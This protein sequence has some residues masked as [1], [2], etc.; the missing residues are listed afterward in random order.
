M[1]ELFLVTSDSKIYTEDLHNPPSFDVAA[2]L[3][4]SKLVGRLTCQNI[5]DRTG[6]V[7]TPYKFK[8]FIP[9]PALPSET[10]ALSF[11]DLC[12]DRAHELIKYSSD[13]GKPLLVMWSGGIDSTTLLTALIKTK[14]LDN[15]IVGMSVH[16]IR[17]NP[18]FYYKHIR[19]K[20]KTI[21]S[22]TALSKIKND[23]ILVTGEGA[24]QLFG[25]DIYKKINVNIGL[26]VMME[27]YSKS[28]ITSFLRL[29]NMT[30]AEADKWFF[31]LDDQIKHTQLCEIKTFK[32]FWWWYNFCYKWQFVFFR[33]L[34]M[35]DQIGR[36]YITKDW[37]NTN[38][39][40]FFMT[41]AFQRWSML[42]PNLKTVDTWTSYKLEAK[43]YIFEFD[44]NQDYFDN[45]V[46]MS[47]MINLIGSTHSIIGGMDSDYE[48]LPPSFDLTPYRQMENSFV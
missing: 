35:A 27:P 19:G 10:N 16:S 33:T 1:S 22:N 26:G 21:P 38:F 37:I 36:E 12:D 42:N 48:M 44:K 8:R 7:N 32:D 40:Q 13:I 28:N 23:M 30:D 18:N 14:S 15:I 24:D 20:I 46:K 4:I 39:K 47:S 29:V 34:I 11:S 3:S 31:V 6:Y 45:K 43:K 25:T 17:E 5:C 2:Y 41:N 9:I